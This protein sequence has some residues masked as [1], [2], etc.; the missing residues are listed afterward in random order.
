[1]HRETAIR[2]L[3]ILALLAP[4]PA[5][6]RAQDRTD[7]EEI[8]WPLPPDPPRVRYVGVLRSER[9]IGKKGSFLSR[10]RSGLLGERE[11]L[12][13]V[14]RP[15]DVHVAPDGKIYV[16]NGSP[17]GILVFD[18][19]EKSSRLLQPR[20]R[21]RLSKAMGITGDAEGNIFVADPSGRRVVA[22]TPEG[23]LIRAYGGAQVLLNPVDVALSRDGSKVYV[24]DSYLHQ[25]LIFD[26]ESGELLERIGKNEGSLAEKTA[27]KSSVAHGAEEAPADPHV[28]TNEPSDLVENRGGG[29]GEFRYPSFLAVAP[30]G[31]LYV[32]DAMNF[33]VQAFTPEGEYKL[34]FGGMG[35]GPGRF[36]RP[37]GLAVDSEGH[38]YVADAAFSNIQ[39]F[40]ADGR[41]LMA[42]AEGGNAEGQLNMPIGVTFDDRDRIFVADR[43]NDRI[44]VFEYLGSPEEERPTGQP[45]RR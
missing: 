26:R 38:I 34:E 27:R 19:D 3:L 45:E 15:W 12:L 28:A 5:A 41:L 9:D 11:R 37:K 20:G 16:T 31:T 40:D 36:A 32:T 23:D 33:R 17:T 6:V 10:L 24:A 43:Y 22:M 30:D 44:Q 35:D 39:I 1:M 8:V 2:V 7:D 25:V 13:A 29:P 4:A 42:F 21:A 18:P 14:T